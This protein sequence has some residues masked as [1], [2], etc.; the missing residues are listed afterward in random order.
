MISNS[1]FKTKTYIFISI[2]ITVLLF[3]IFY[4]YDLQVIKSKEYQTRARDLSLRINTIP[5]Q[6]G[7]IY[8]RNGNN[9]LVVNIDSFAVNIIPAELDEDKLD[10]L[11][12][13]LSKILNMKPDSIIAKLP[14]NLKNQY[15]PI[16]IKSGIPLYTINL[17]AEKI[18]DFKGVTWI[19]KP[20][21]SYLQSGSVSHV[22]GYVGD[23]TSE[24]FQIL[25]N[26]IPL[27]V[28]G[29]PRKNIS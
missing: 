15:L 7:K 27:P 20:I 10:S 6:R 16:E 11:I 22:L 24:E 4:L 12:L 26:K 13:E 23:I 1:T 28:I 18:E 19:S 25:Y 3:Y 29:N 8:D 21:R 9:P 5:A 2:I 17:I 14:L